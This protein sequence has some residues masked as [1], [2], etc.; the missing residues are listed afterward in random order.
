LANTVV[1]FQL[2]SGALNAGNSAPGFTV[3]AN[4]TSCC[5]D[6]ASGT[7]SMMLPNS[8]SGRTPSTGAFRFSPRYTDAPR[9]K[10]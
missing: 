6:R 8:W 10:A 5:L 4:C 3:I 1:R 2:M 9:W 7:T